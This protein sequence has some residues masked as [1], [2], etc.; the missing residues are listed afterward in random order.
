MNQLKFT[1]ERPQE[2]HPINAERRINS[3][4]REENQFLSRALLFT[5]VLA[6]LFFGAF[7]AVMSVAGWL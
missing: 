3:A 4:L 6:G 7:M 2:E 1:S 5:E